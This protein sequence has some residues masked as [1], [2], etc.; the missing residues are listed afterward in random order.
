MILLW[1]DSRDIVN[2][3]ITYSDSTTLVV[4]VVGVLTCH[5]PRL[6]NMH[7]FSR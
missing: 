3:T 2:L 5:F 1:Y 4:V 7:I 6:L